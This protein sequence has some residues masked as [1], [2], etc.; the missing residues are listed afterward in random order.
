MTNCIHD[1]SRWG[2]GDQLGAANLLTS[3]NTME[4][5]AGVQEGVTYDLSQIIEMGAKNEAGSNLERIEM[6]AH[7][8]TH[9][10]ALGHFTKGMEMYG[11]RSSSD[12][13]G[14]FGLNNL[15][16]EHIPP[17]ITRG[18]CINVSNLDNDNYLEAGRAVTREDLEQDLDTAGISSLKTADVVC[19]HTGWG[20]FFMT[21]NDKYVA[22]EPG[23]ELGAAE[24]LTS[25]NILAI[26]SDN[27]A[28]EV[29]PGTDH[30]RIIDACA[31]TRFSR[32]WG[33][34]D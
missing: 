18:V 14:D 23:I 20:Q 10:D 13:V 7:V 16:I 11:G 19:I 24:W 31:S 25:Q 9:I 2:N 8:G 28:I 33:L 29:L 15:G 30:P 6:T 5:L 27:M 17:V 22:G 26:A 32:G 1:H 4:A 3:K 34:L 21:D 12:E